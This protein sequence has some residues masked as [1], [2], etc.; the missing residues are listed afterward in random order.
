MNLKSKQ[1][2]GAKVFLALF[3]VLLFFMNWLTSGEASLQ[4]YDTIRMVFPLFLISISIILYWLR[5]NYRGLY[6]TLEIVFAVAVFYGVSL[7]A[8]SSAMF[9]AFSIRQDQIAGIT[10]FV[11]AMYVFVR[12]M[13]NVANSLAEGGKALAVWNAIFDF[14]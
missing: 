9:D 7:S 13:D 11:G 3:V 1:I 12:G 5:L 4:H 2:L 6:G 10:A 8:S 14:K